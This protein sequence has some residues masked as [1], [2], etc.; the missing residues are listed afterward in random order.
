[1]VATLAIVV[2]VSAPEGRR[3]GRGPRLVDVAA[4]GAAV[5]VAIG[6]SSGKASAGTL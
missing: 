6:L 3:R 5:A 2:T 1:M 4:I